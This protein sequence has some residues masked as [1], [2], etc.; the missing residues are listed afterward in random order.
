MDSA[1]APGL[2]AMPNSPPLEVPHGTHLNTSHDEV[3]HPSYQKLVP[4]N[5]ARAPL[6]PRQ[7]FA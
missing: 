5:S 4:L 2:F 7:A 3:V 1:F 6:I